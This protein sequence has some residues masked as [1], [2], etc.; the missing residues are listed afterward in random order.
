M[1]G[2]PRY[3]SSAGRGDS[4]LAPRPGHFVR[5]HPKAAWPSQPTDLRHCL[6]PPAARSLPW[7]SG[8]G[9]S[10]LGQVRA[11]LGMSELAS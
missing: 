9:M 8:L 3:R 5:L 7:T 6:E 1:Q 4:G 2:C 11:G 10:E